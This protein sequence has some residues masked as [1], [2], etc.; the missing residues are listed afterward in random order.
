MEPCGSSYGD[1]SHLLLCVP[2]LVNINICLFRL[3]TTTLS[4]TFLIA[5]YLPQSPLV[6]PFSWNIFVNI[7]L[8]LC[9]SDSASPDCRIRNS[10]CQVQFVPEH[11]M[12][13]ITLQYLEE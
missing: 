12:S 13:R 4:S 6:F 10:Q 11:H 1:I 9:I 2:Q 5:Q 3:Y 8:M 7:Q